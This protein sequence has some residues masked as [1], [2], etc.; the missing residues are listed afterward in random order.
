MNKREDIF[1][2]LAF[3]DKLPTQAQIRNLILKASDIFTFRANLKKFDYMKD[4][5][6]LK[7]YLLYFV[8]VS[9]KKQYSVFREIFAH[10]SFR[11]KREIK[12]I[13]IGCGPSPAVIP[14]FNLMEEKIIE[15]EYI[16][17][18]GIESE[19]KAISFAERLIE[20]LK[21]RGLTLK[22]EFINADFS[23]IQDFVDL[24]KIQ[25][26]I[27]LFSNSLS[28]IL[29][30]GKVNVEEIVKFLK[31]FTYKSSNFTVII[32]EPA[33][34]K[35]SMRLHRLRD[36]F[37]KELNLYPYSPCL[38]DLPCSALRANN[39][40]YEERKW[41]APEYL[42]FL[43]SKGLQINY[44]KFSYLILRKD[45]TNIR[46]LF[47]TEGEIMKNTSHLL[48][49]KGKSRLWACYEGELIDV[50]KLK[51]DFRENEPFLNLRKGDYFSIDRFVFLSH[52]K[53]RL[54]REC[55][56]KLLYSPSLENLQI[57]PE[58][59]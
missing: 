16:R 55:N 57:Y 58:K 42:K 43:S 47:E 25:P 22:S 51:R 53:V 23:S 45:K 38:N 52:R 30:Q 18:L 17:Y 8:P 6:L 3:P 27:I 1:L 11:D 32:I 4:E 54:Q 29:E 2:R 56:V 19:K 48:N 41:N 24:R 37:I 35:F 9:I 26:D 40:C 39:W 10:P 12:I 34:K 50:E 28:E 31:N 21:P 20:Q 46:E 7:G 14:L 33:T 36:I 5:E 44:L 59:A 15:L 49:E 13:D